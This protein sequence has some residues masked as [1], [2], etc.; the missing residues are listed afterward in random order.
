MKSKVW[1]ASTPKPARVT[2]AEKQRIVTAC[3]AFIRDVL[4]PRF[5]PQI[6]PTEWN[7]PVDIHG[8]WAGGRY[9][10]VQRYRSGMEH[11]CRE[12]FDAPFARIDSMGLNRFDI[13][14]M[15]H[16]GK[17]WRLYTGKTLAEAL[18]ILEDDGVLHPLP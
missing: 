6:I 9:R 1:A 16:T 12:E 18:Q 10:F 17:W 7:Y 14:W 5:M 11:N 8:V 15:R 13:Y 3:E 4:K 2:D